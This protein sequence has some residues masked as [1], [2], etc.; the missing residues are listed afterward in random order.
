M[1]YV[2][3]ARWRAKAGRADEVA[4]I[5]AR[6]AL[7][8]RQES[9]VITFIAHRNRSDDHE[10]MIYEQFVDAEALKL[11]DSAPHYARNVIRD[12]LPLLESREREF[13]EQLYV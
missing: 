2:V 13:Y 5:L 8:T 3:T 10:F 1:S 4:A 6:H 9:G 12:A 11:H 7:E